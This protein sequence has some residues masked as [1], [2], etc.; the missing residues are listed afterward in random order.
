MNLPVGKFSQIVQQIRP[1]QSIIR[2]IPGRYFMY[3]TW[4]FH[5]HMNSF[6]KKKDPWKSRASRYDR[7]M[8]CSVCT[9][10]VDFLKRAWQP[11]GR[12][13]EP[14]RPHVITEKVLPHSSRQREQHPP[15][16]ISAQP[17]NQN[18]RGSGAG[19]IH[20]S[21]K[22]VV[23]KESGSYLLNSWKSR[24]CFVKPRVFCLFGMHSGY[25]A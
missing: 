1:A 9:S 5:F 14:D 12:Q 2:K 25:L 7:V 15:N 11:F 23:G 16:F 6:W 21:F 3:G 8:S 24:L 13:N 19:E 20:A 18:S 10:T 22:N 17:S 4:N